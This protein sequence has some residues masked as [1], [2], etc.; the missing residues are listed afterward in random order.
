MDKLKRFP[1]LATASLAL[2]VVALTLF[3]MDWL[4]LDDTSILTLISSA[5]PQ[6][7]SGGI[8]FAEGL[9]MVHDL[10]KTVK[11]AGSYLG[12]SISS[13]KDTLSWLYIGYM[14]CFLGSFAA[15][16]FCFYSRLKWKP[17]YM[18]ALYLPIIVL[19]LGIMYM[20]MDK[21]NAVLG[22]GTFHISLWAIAAVVC[23]LLSEIFWEEAS[24]NTPN[25]MIDPQPAQP[26]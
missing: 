26:Q 12:S 15:V 21:I 23:A 2:L 6:L 8:S 11:S 16:G 7:E 17:G 9:E 14:A 19:D 5:V 10:S 1:K 18:E 24:F 25:P 13:Y 20:F 22:A 4:T 3:W